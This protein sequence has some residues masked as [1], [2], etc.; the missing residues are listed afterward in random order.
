MQKITFLEKYGGWSLIVLFTLIPVFIWFS[1]N[2]FF[3]IFSSYSVAMASLG[4]LFG[5]VGFTLFSINFVLS[6][7]AKW[8]EK[9]FNGINSAYKAHHF[10][11]GLA[12]CLILFHPIFLALKYIEWTMLNTIKDAAQFLLPRFIDFS[13]SS[14]QIQEVIAMN[15]G[16]IAFFGVLV[17]LFVTFYVNIPYQVWLLTH[18]FLGL[19]FV[20]AGVHVI[21]ISSDTSRSPLLFGY[22]LFWFVIGLLCY[23]YKTIMGGFVIR[24]F[25]YVIKKSYSNSGILT[26]QLTPVNKSIIVKEGQFVLMSVLSS[27]KV[28]SK[29]YHPFSVTSIATDG[30][31]GLCIKS[32]GDYTSHLMNVPEETEVLLEGAY[33]SFGKVNN[34]KKPQIWIAGG[35]GITPFLSMASKLVDRN[36]PV[37]LFYS[38]ES[39][40]QLLEQEYLKSVFNQNQFRLENYVTSEHNGYMTAKFIQSVAGDLNNF[41]FFICGPSGM[42]KGLKKQLIELGV[43]SY[44]IH[45]EEFNFS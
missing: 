11:G 33:G 20:F 42:M 22:L 29:E 2:P 34:L 23:I 19:A 43:K 18:K 38:V 41:E 4:K 26:L 24:R 37:I 30:S 45:S 15:A 39:R 36:V 17:L 25:K 21:L 13:A 1:L 10:V 6:T 3:E 28:V 14:Q 12:F 27:S 35:I 44:N 7:R 8:L 16:S 32:L 40:E 31:I 9:F 5:I